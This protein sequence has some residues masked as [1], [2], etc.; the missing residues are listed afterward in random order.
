MIDTAKM[1][2]RGQVVIPKSVRDFIGASEET[3]FAVSA[4]DK[5]TVVMRKL[6]TDRLLQEFRKLRKGALTFSRR[7]IEEEIDA[8]RRA[9]H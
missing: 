5:E 7:E 9:R 2:E 3:L 4:L 8:A 6:D 1:S